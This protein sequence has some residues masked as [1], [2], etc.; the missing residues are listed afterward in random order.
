[1]DKPAPPKGRHAWRDSQP[2]RNQ[3]VLHPVGRQRDD[4]ASLHHA[5]RRGAPPRQLL[6][7]KPRFGTQYNR[8][9]YTHI[10]VSSYYEMTSTYN[11]LY[12]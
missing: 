12:L 10:K 1:L 3:L 2:L 8:W 6:Q 5:H 11:Q 4:A 7:C 9:S